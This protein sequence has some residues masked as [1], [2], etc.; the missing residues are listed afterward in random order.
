MIR[1]GSVIPTYISLTIYLGL[2][3]LLAIVLIFISG[4]LSPSKP[5]ASKLQPY[6]CGIS[7]PTPTEARWPV[8]FALVAMLFL[9]FDVEALFLYPWAVLMRQLSWAGIGV[10]ASFFVILGVGYIYARSR[11]ALEWR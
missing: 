9:V 10:I 1:E 8:R 4:K 7:E 5:T 11:G 2:A 6:E 3:G